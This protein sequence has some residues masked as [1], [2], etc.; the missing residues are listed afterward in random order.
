MVRGLRPEGIK[1]WRRRPRGAWER[2]RF[3][4]AVTVAGLSLLQHLLQ[5]EMAVAQ[6]TPL[7]RLSALF[8]V[9]ASVGLAALQRSD[10]VS[11]EVLLDIGLAFEVSGAFALGAM[12]NALA[13][14]DYPVRGATGV[15]VWV[16][17]CM[18]V[19]SNRP[20]KSAAA[21]LLSAVMLPCAHLLAAEI[22]G[23][24]ASAVEPAGRLQH[25]SLLRRGLD[26]FHQHA[27]SPDA[28]GAEPHQRP[29]AVTSWQSCWAKAGWARCGRRA[30]GCC[31]G[32]PR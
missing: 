25:Q 22:T 29:R 9:L 30:T 8:L 19:I 7:F 15:A 10:F 24:S 12:E 13:W 5:P 21:A 4:R 28:D 6:Q 20:W 16:G 18:V 17:L 27:I 3:S 23:L 26:P 14:P 1:M 11:A 32:M 31:G 2:W